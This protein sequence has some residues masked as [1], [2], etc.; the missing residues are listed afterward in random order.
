MR[1]NAAVLTKAILGAT[2][3]VR[4]GGSDECGTEVAGSGGTIDSAGVGE[5]NVILLKVQSINGL[6]AVSQLCP[7]TAKQLESIGVIKN[8][9]ECFS[10]L[11][12]DTGRS[13]AFWITELVD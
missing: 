4:V 11:G 5:L 12:K 1:A 2:S 7:R 9:M 3:G 10:P 6:Y 8:V 13:V